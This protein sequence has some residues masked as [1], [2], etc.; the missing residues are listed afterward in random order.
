MFTLTPLILFS[1]PF[2][3][4]D[5]KT[6]QTRNDN[7]LT[8]LIV[9]DNKFQILTN[10]NP[11]FSINPLMSVEHRFFSFYSGIV[12]I[13][14]CTSYHVCLFCRWRFALQRKFNANDDGW[15]RLDCVESVLWPDFVKIESISIEKLKMR[16]NLQLNFA[17][18]TLFQN[19]ICVSLAFNSHFTAR[20]EVENCFTSLCSKSQRLFTPDIRPLFERP[21]LN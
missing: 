11:F 17:S 2:N 1:F 21:K 12:L 13:F 19:E 6:I 4:L 15:G 5:G 8:W 3:P 10:F 18:S 20:I 7:F 14:V 16:K 9:S